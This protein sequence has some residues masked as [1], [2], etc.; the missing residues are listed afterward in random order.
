MA[1]VHVFLSFQHVTTVVS[2]HVPCVLAHASHDPCRFSSNVILDNPFTS[3]PLPLG[4]IVQC[5]RVLS[6]FFVFLFGIYG[7]FIRFPVMRRL[8]HRV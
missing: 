1:L 7:L 6:V 4:E 2:A 3:V 5:C 8:S